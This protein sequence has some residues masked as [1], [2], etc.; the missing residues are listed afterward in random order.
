MKLRSLQLLPAFSSLLLIAIGTSTIQ[1]QEEKYEKQILVIPWGND[2]GKLPAVLELGNSQGKSDIT[3]RSIGGGSDYFKV[4]DEGNFY[5]LYQFPQNKG[6]RRG[7]KVFDPMS[8][9]IAGWEAVANQYKGFNTISVSNNKVYLVDNLERKILEFDKKLNFLKEIKIP[10]SF[11]PPWGLDYTF[12]GKGIVHDFYSNDPNDSKRRYVFD[13][14]EWMQNDKPDFLNI[15]RRKIKLE[16]GWS[17][18]QGDSGTV[19]IGVYQNGKTPNLLFTLTQ[20]VS[21]SGNINDTR[22]DHSRIV[23]IDSEG[24]IFIVLMIEPLDRLRP[25]S[26][27]RV[28]KVSPQGKILFQLNGPWTGWR[29]L[30]TVVDKNGNIYMNKWENN[31]FNILIWKKVKK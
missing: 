18:V 2:N 28:F 9:E 1:A 22:S 26:V 7:V 20:D 17:N 13:Q 29:V 27:L 4:D 10:D 15:P 8:R 24:N 12:V 5:L 23:G 6:E 16:A 21:F 25:S 14:E 31:G 11:N 19:T 3:Y 30:D